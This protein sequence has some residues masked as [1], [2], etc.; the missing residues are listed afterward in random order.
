MTTQVRVPA[1]T[2]DPVVLHNPHLRVTAHPVHGFHITELTERAGGANLLWTRNVPVTA[3]GS[4]LG[5]AGEASIRT[6][7]DH[8]FLGG[9][10]LMF[11]N[12]GLPSPDDPEPT[13]M[14]GEAARLP[15]Q[16]VGHTAET[17]TA[18]VHTSDFRV[19]RTLHLSGATLTVSTTATNTTSRP[20]D[21]SFGEH[22]CFDRAQF[23]GGRLE[24]D[25]AGARVP[26]PQAQLDAAR[27]RPQRIEHWPEA[28]TTSGTVSDA[29][30]MPDNADGRHDHI[31]VDLADGTLALRSPVLRGR[32]RMDIDTAHLPHALIWQHYRPTA[33][34][35][36]GDIIAIEPSS[37]PGRTT[38]DART[39]GALR[40]LHP[41]EELQFEVR[42]TW[43]P[44]L[45]QIRW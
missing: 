45:L 38:A 14:H 2:S 39:S 19:R 4:D 3:V 13:W 22:P 34:P 41:G 42:T 10:F 37:A 31:S 16:V 43:E 33:S 28:H 6:F 24:L 9:W 5:P 30:A 8:L 44:A 25:A 32:L 12:A 11:P 23:A 20:R 36:N 27:F 15:W 29:A 21:V 35:W 18:E 40:T 7:D 1:R 26:I 17:V